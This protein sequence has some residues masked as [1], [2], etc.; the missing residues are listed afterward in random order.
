MISSHFKP[1]MKKRGSWYRYIYGTH[2]DLKVPLTSR[3]KLKLWRVRKYF[4]FYWQ[5]YE[6]LHPQELHRSRKALTSFIIV[7]CCVLK[8]PTSVK[9]PTPSCTRHYSPGVVAP[10]KAGPIHEPTRSKLQP[11]RSYNSAEA[12]WCASHSV[13]LLV[14]FQRINRPGSHIAGCRLSSWGECTRWMMWGWSRRDTGGGYVA[15]SPGTAAGVVCAT[16][17]PLK[18]QAGE[19]DHISP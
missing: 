18:G 2:L 1:Q 11:K 5:N 16:E 15:F 7:E 19:S 13:L 9:T 4:V 10:G 8:I 12:F 17:L 3:G 6:I 14:G